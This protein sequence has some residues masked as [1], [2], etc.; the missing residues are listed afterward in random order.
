M[1]K[2]MD[3]D[4]KKKFV[5]SVIDDIKEIKRFPKMNFFK[6]KFACC[7]KKLQM[8]KRLLDKS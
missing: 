1:S 2:K 4:K 6:L 7:S 3:R 8:H 5:G